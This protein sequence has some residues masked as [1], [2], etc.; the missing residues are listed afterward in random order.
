MKGEDIKAGSKPILSK[1]KGRMAPAVAASVVI[2]IKL[3]PTA[4][5]INGPSPCHHAK[6]KTTII[7]NIPNKAPVTASFTTAFK[8]PID[9]NFCVLKPLITTVEL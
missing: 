4:N 3:I 1:S 7:I 5:A 2:E 6:G 8:A 9:F